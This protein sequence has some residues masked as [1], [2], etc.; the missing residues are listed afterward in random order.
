[1]TETSHVERKH[2]RHAISLSLIVS[3]LDGIDDTQ[4]ER[5]ELQD[6]SGGGAS[7][8]STDIQ[9]Y[10]IG[11]RLSL[12]LELPDHTHEDIRGMVMWTSEAA[13]PSDRALVGMCL[14]DLSSIER[15][16]AAGY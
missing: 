5:T 8:F 11:Q 6:I 13:S 7:F 4:S 15:I 3:T 12:D 10:Y 1:M 9:N 14:D 16:L 2:T